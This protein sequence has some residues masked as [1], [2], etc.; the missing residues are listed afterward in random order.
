VKATVPGD[1][2][3]WVAKTLNGAPL[4]GTKTE[5]ITLQ[6]PVVVLPLANASYSGT[7]KVTVTWSLTEAYKAGAA[8]PDR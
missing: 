5:T 3:A 2:A 1:I 8:L 7:A 4:S 6:R